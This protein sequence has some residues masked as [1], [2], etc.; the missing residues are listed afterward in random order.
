MKKAIAVILLLTGGIFVLNY[1]LE[2]RRGNRNRSCNEDF[3]KYCSQVMNNRDRQAMKDC[4]D[5]NYENF[6]DECKKAIDFR[7]ERRSRQ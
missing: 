5:E 4:I 7:N 1:S 6:S 2:A 3:K